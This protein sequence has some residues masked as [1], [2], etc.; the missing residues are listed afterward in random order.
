MRFWRDMP[1]GVNLKS[2][3]FA[4]T[5]SI[6]MK[7]YSFPEWCRRN[8]LEDFEP[9]TMQSFAA[10]GLDVQ[11]RFVPELEQTLVTRVERARR[12]FETTLASGEVIRSVESW[13]ALVFLD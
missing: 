13:F 12:D 7:G 5:I 4:T 8:G 11:T 9:C 10:Y 2:F 3:A 6:P 1:I